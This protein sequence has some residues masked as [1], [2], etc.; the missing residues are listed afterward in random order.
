MNAQAWL[1]PRLLCY[2]LE[3]LTSYAGQIGTHHDSSQAPTPTARSFVHTRI[4]L[5]ESTIEALT[6]RIF[7]VR[8]LDNGGNTGCLWL[9]E[10][11]SSRTTRNRRAWPARRSPEQSGNIGARCQYFVWNVFRE[12]QGYIRSGKTLRFTIRIPIRCDKGRNSHLHRSS[13]ERVKR[14][15]L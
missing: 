4:C 2:S 11:S 7:L 10:F 5:I 3:L 14:L 1:L 12:F 15:V 13:E 6:S 9:R 8:K